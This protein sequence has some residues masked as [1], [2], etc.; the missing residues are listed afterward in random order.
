LS[1][2][3]PPVRCPK[4]GQR[5]NRFATAF[6][7]AA[8]EFGPVDCM[9]CGRSFERNEYLMLLAEARAQTPPPIASD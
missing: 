8:E 9:V 2:G 3:I 4:C 6:D 5:Q 1:N 7:P